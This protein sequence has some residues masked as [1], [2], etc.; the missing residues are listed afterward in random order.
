MSDSNFLNVEEILLLSSCLFQSK[1]F[2]QNHL[3]QLKPWSD[4]NTLAQNTLNLNVYSILFGIEYYQKIIQRR[5]AKKN[6]V[7]A[8]LLI[9][10]LLGLLQC[11]IKKGKQNL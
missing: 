5:N 4:F 8:T 3:K 11:S 1:S 9:D 10:C 2:S 6:L 7:A